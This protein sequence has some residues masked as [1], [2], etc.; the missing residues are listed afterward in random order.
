MTEKNVRKSGKEKAG[1]SAGKAEAALSFEEALAGL[2][3]SVESLKSEGTTL[4]SVIK[5]FEE[6]MAFY[7]RCEEMLKEAKQKIEI[8][9]RDAL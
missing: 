7:N 2:E 1:A 8:H 5:S 9:G 3:G 6:G 4:E